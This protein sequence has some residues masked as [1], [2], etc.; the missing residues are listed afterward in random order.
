MLPALSPISP[1]NEKF[2]LLVVGSVKEWIM[3]P[4]ALGRNNNHTLVKTTAITTIHIAIFFFFIFTFPFILDNFPIY[5]A[6]S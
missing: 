6:V 3:F 4:N 5:Q 1:E 2:E